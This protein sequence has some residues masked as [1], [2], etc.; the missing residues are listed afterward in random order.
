M[1]KTRIRHGQKEGL[2]LVFMSIIC[3]TPMLGGG[4]FLVAELALTA[5][6][7]MLDLKVVLK[8]GKSLTVCILLYLL[9]IV[10]YRVTGISDAAWGRYAVYTLEEMQMIL[11]LIIPVKLMGNNTTWAWWLMLSVIGV[12]IAWNITI[13]YLYPEI[14]ESIHHFDEMFIKSL[15]LGLSDFHVMSLMFF[16]V[17]FFV[18]L[19]CKKKTIKYLMLGIS[20]I[21]A[22]YIVGFCLKASVVV[23]LMLSIG[24]LLFTKRAK[25]TGRAILLLSIVSIIALLLISV[26]ADTIVKIIVDLSPS[27]RLSKRLVMLVDADSSYASDNSFNARVDLW[28]SSVFTWLDNVGSFLFGVGDHWGNSSSGVGQ[29]SDLLDHLAKYGL[30]GSMLFFAI[31]IK[32]FKY[33]LSIFDRKYRLQLLMIF[34]IYILCGITKRIFFLNVGVVLY[35]LLPMASYFVNEKTVSHHAD[36]RA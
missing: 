1:G 29:H 21:A 32:A 25:T 3:C 7:I 23:F 15:N 33:I 28:Y 10:T 30:L 6:I 12:N 31:M 17:C 16:N 36:L 14:N 27:E 11:M 18:F 26:Y 35:L 24:L 20:L 8:Q 34:L 22:L 5:L 13:C 9:L 4:L 2:L 19:N